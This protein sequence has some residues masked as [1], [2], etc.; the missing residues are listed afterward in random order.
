MNDDYKKTEKLYEIKEKYGVADDDI[1]FAILEANDEFLKNLNQA[2]EMSKN[3]NEVIKTIN[4]NLKMINARKTKTNILLAILI[5]FLSFA[6]GIFFSM[7]PIVN[8]MLIGYQVQMHNE[9]T[10]FEKKYNSQLSK[11]QKD[12]EKKRDALLEDFEIQ[13][14]ELQAEKNKAISQYK[15][16]KANNS[17]TRKLGE[18]DVKLKLHK[19]K[20]DGIYTLYIDNEDRSI[21]IPSSSNNNISFKPND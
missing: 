12:Y 17:I 19:N 4:K 13:K 8:D 21:Y 2:Y 11:I 3:H 6:G 15:N 5:F 1:V 18:L 9:S 16:L 10:K 14:I 7:S 20:N